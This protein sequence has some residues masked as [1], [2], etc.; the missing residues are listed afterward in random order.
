MHLSRRSRLDFPRYSSSVLRYIIGVQ[1]LNNARFR[2]MPTERLRLGRIFAHWGDRL[3]SSFSYLHMSVESIITPFL[4]IVLFVT[5][6]D[7]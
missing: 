7:S 2:G 1:N 6:R 4:T 5:V 3:L